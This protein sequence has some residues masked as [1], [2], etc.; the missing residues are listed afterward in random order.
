MELNELYQSYTAGDL[1]KH[2][3]IAAMHQKH[4][5]L[6]EYQD[7]LKGTDIA[8]ITIE[9]DAV[10]VTMKET[11]IRL[12]VDP[13]DS[14]FIPV[15]ILNF[16]SFDPV[17]R[18]LIFRLARESKTIFD[19]GA[20]IGWYTLNFSALEN[21]EKVY[22]FEP[23]P[24]TFDYLSRHVELN[25]CRKAVLNNIA[26]AEENGETTFYWNRRE[27]GS[28][29]MKNIQE[30]DDSAE[31]T[32][33]LRALDDFV[34]ETGATIDMIKC[35]VEGSELMVFTGGLATLE[36]DK[37]FIFTEMLR[38]WSAKFDYH[39]NDIIELLA[40][41][42]Y[43]CFAYVDGKPVQIQQVTDTTEATNYFF[44]DQDKHKNIIAACFP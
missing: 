12:F 37:P 2:D 7:Y 13:D 35:D 40:T 24:H 19:I 1:D 41:I 14:R 9:N 30:R 18:D 22:S 44:L 3:Y 25:N 4:R 33:Q 10:L 15:E 11:G 8:S 31:I 6:F 32:C 5:L 27:T 23:I 42:G 21:V 34:A 28:S 39:P 29:S 43:A 17:E 38:K 20:N 36:R 16:K 26:L